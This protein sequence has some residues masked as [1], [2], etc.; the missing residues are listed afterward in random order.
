MIPSCLN[1]LYNRATANI[2]IKSYVTWNL[3]PIKIHSNGPVPNK[4][5]GAELE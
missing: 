2:I 1:K 3:V 4:Y 5:L